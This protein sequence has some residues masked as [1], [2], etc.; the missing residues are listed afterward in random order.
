[1][2]GSAFL[3]LLLVVQAPAASAPERFFVGRTAGSG[4]IRVVLSGQHSFRVRS[5]G[6]LDRSGALLLEQTVQEEGKAVRRRTWRLVRSGTNRISGTLS[7][8][9]GPVSGEIAG[10]VL[11][12]RYA[13][14]EGGTVDQRITFHPNGRTAENRM[15]IRRFGVPVATVEETI[16]RVD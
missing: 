16:R 5:V 7:D 15:T 11:S 12:L 3:A 14:A 6:R 9:R 8:A 10:R 1:M 2:L 4:T 13:P